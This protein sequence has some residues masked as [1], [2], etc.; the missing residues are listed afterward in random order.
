MCYKEGRLYTGYGTQFDNLMDASDADWT[1]DI[2]GLLN[3]IYE[4]AGDSQPIVIELRFVA[5]SRLF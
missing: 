1:A 3:H 2:I 5:G 4:T